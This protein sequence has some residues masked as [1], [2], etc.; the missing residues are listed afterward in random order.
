MKRLK[1][2][3]LIIPIIFFGAL[4]VQAGT[5]TDGTGVGIYY[6]ASFNSN[7]GSPSYSSQNHKAKSTVSSPGSPSKTGYTFTGWSPSLP[8]SMP[9][10]NTTYM[11]NYADRTKPTTPGPMTT[12]WV[13]DHFVKTSCTAA[14]TGSVDSGSGIRGYR[15]CRSNN[16]T[17]GC[18]V[19]VGSEH[20]GKTQS[21]SGSNL[22]S[23]GPYRY[24]YW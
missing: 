4:S 19:W 22:P 11:A 18:S 8:A 12:S 15:L 9:S 20:S 13:R 16:N 14:T 23:N 24:Y 7:G 2:L 3:L 5:I 17:S 6:I 21:V 1:T 10:A